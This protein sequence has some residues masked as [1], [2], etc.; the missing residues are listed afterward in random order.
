MVLLCGNQ[1]VAAE[2][3]CPPGM[4][5]PNPADTSICYPFPDQQAQTSAQQ[6]PQAPSGRWETRWGAIATDNV[7]GAFAGVVNFSSKQVA[8]KAAVT[9]C[10]VNGGGENCK[11]LLTYYNQC[12][13]IAAGDTA[14]TAQ[15]AETIKV[16]SELALQKCSNKTANC[17]IYYSDCS[18]PVWISY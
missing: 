12:S 18:P 13:A 15:G 10:K 5:P 2:G 9:Q 7:A 6:Q 11:T 16:A 17:K 14:H 3:G 8:Q 1:I 4:Y